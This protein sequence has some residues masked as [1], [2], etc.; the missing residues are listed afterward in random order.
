MRGGGRLGCKISVAQ[1]LHWP[2]MR[3]GLA[4][5]LPAGFGGQ[6]LLW[7]TAP[8]AAGPPQWL[9]PAASFWEPGAIPA[10]PRADDR[11]RRR[12]TSSSGGDVS[13]R[14]CRRRPERRS[15]QRQKKMNRATGTKMHRAT[16]R[17]RGRARSSSGGRSA[18]SESPTEDGTLPLG[19]SFKV[20]GFDGRAAQRRICGTVRAPC[21]GARSAGHV[22]QKRPDAFA[23]RHR[24][25]S[26][27]ARNLPTGGRE[28]RNQASAPGRIIQD[29]FVCGV[30]AFPGACA[31]GEDAEAGPRTPGSGAGRSSPPCS[32]SV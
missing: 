6:Q 5:G 1:R 12:S 24:H 2:A 13:A 18:S 25:T 9:G 14:S 4:P 7:P 30:G 3:P 8:S 22:L 10:A 20:L 26:R 32:Q 31:C 28:I 27:T 23:R 19:K 16:G 29:T 15:T 17:T 11:G 21:P